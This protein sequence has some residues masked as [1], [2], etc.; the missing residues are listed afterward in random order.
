MTILRWRHLPIVGALVGA[1][2]VSALAWAQPP[3]HATLPVR[4]QSRLGVSHAEEVD[5]HYREIVDPRR[6]HHGSLSYSNTSH[7]R[8]KGAARLP[9]RGPHHHVLEQHLGRPTHWGT[10][11]LVEGLQRAAARVAEQFPGTSTG[12]GN[13]SAQHGGDIPWS[14]SHNSGRDADVSFYFLDAKRQPARVTTLLHVRGPGLTVP[15]TDLRLDVP[16]SWAF[17]EALIEDD[18]LRL[19]WLFVSNPIRDALLAHG[20]SVGASPRVLAVAEAVLR[21]P[22]NA[23]PHDDHFHVRIHCAL[24]DRLDGCVEWGPRRADLFFDDAAIRRRVTELLRGL[25]DPDPEIARACLDF[26]VLMEPREGG[27]LIADSIET[28]PEGFRTPLLTLAGTLGGPDVARALLRFVE[29]SDQ[30][31]HV[32]HAY[33]LLGGIGAH[34][35]AMPLAEIAADPTL[36]SWRRQA[37]ADAL[38]TTIQPRLAPILIRALTSVQPQFETPVLTTLQ[39]LTVHR[40]DAG[41]VDTDEDALRA[42]ADAWS[43]WWSEN[44]L[45]DPAEGGGVLDDAAWA[46]RREAWLQAGFL[47]AGYTIG[48]VDAPDTGELLRALKDPR[49][50]I[51]WNADRRL[52]EITGIYR[53]ARRFQAE[54]SLRFWRRRVAVPWRTSSR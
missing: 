3:E 26:L 24:D 6:Q 5:A 50:E 33:R 38:Q 41:V 22:G 40:I 39:R 43:A 10:T 20:R 17:V 19:Q 12:I 27:A 30:D 47:D 53:S 9:D 31:A 44:G 21:Q 14:V 45:P 32:L 29:S 54:E 35:T 25:H 4:V 37:A 23:A 7:G 11:E 34:A 42:R 28:S 46:E 52:V 18:A 51:A 49:E 1:A 13:L 15:G 2:C 48:T 16:R 36:D 8:L